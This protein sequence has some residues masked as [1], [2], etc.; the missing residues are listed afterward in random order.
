MSELKA[1]SIESFLSQ[2]IF[3]SLVD[4]NSETVFDNSFNAHNFLDYAIDEILH[5]LKFKKPI[6]TEKQFSTKLRLALHFA[7]KN[8]INFDYS[9]NL[10]RFKL[11]EE[12]ITENFS[13]LTPEKI[14]VLARS[15]SV[16]LNSWDKSRKQGVRQKKVIKDTIF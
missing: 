1:E 6:L 3:S 4:S 2:S 13:T 5:S 8:A 7:P 12:F 16:V 9:S 10:S 14:S 15:V 11:I